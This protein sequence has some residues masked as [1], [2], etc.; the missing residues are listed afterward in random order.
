MLFFRSLKWNQFFVLHCFATR[1]MKTALFN[2][3]YINIV[4]YMLYVFYLSVPFSS[5]FIFIST[6]LCLIFCPLPTAIVFLMARISE[7]LVRLLW[8]NSSL[9]VYLVGRY[10]LFCC[11]S[12]LTFYGVSFSPTITIFHK[13]HLKIVC[14]V[15]V[16]VD[17]GQYMVHWRIQRRKP[18]QRKWQGDRWMLTKFPFHGSLAYM[19]H[20]CTFM[21]VLFTKK[22]MTDPTMARWLYTYIYCSV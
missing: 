1:S 17:T 5:L 4:R 22:L 16:W 19:S 12:H 20:G 21:L 2:W 14:D 9:K 11:S 8:K 6:C 13:F 7:L 18:F 10:I 3:F 15:H